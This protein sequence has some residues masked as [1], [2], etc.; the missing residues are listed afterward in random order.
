MRPIAI[1][2]ALLLATILLAPPAHADEALKKR[3]SD[4]ELIETLKDMGYRAVEKTEDR[5]LSIAIDGYTHFLY[6][7]DDD[8]LQLYF[9]L[10]GYKVTADDMN[11]WNRTK[12]LS[13][14]YL[15]N[16]D[17]PVLEADLLANAG[18]TTRQLNEWISV[19]DRSAREFHQFVSAADRSE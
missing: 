13:R 12:R 6:V 2:L 5:V 14:A 7:Y 4:D 8:D 11:E 17:D 19:F 10:T 1:S 9:G 16:V 15:D 18:F 3:Y